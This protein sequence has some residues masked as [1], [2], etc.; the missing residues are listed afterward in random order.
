MVIGNAFNKI[1][2]AI[3]VPNKNSIMM[4]DIFNIKTSMGSTNNTSL[5]FL[6]EE[7]LKEFNTI[8]YTGKTSEGE[9]ISRTDYL[10]SLGKGEFKI[11]QT[12]YDNGDFSEEFT[13]VRVTVS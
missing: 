8:G 2:I 12:K 13:I 10:N 4:I 9:I 3:F 7:E 11:N 6:T 5:P 1:I